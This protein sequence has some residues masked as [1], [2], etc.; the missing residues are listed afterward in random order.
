VQVELDALRCQKK[1]TLAARMRHLPAFTLFSADQ[2]LHNPH[3]RFP[4]RGFPRRNPGA[5]FPLLLVVT[6]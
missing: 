5:P 2:P 4:Q 6:V 1:L 3:K